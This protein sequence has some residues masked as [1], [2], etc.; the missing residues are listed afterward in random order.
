[1]IVVDNAICRFFKISVAA[2]YFYVRYVCCLKHFPL[3]SY[4][5]CIRIP[6]TFCRTYRTFC[7][8]L[9]FH[10]Q[11]KEAEVEDVMNHGTSLHA[12]T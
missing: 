5:F 6:M 8:C 11:L 4:L 9:Q 7:E 12:V 10:V 2:S 1:M 3:P